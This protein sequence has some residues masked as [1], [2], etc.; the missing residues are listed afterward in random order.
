VTLVLSALTFWFVP[1]TPMQ[2][3]FLSDLEKISLLEHV[4][5]NQTG[6]SNRQH[7][8][9]AQLREA[10]SDPQLWAQWLIILLCG[11]GGGVI[12]TYS[13]T[14]IKGFGYTPKESA[15]LNMGGGAV[16]VTYCLLTSYGVRMFGQRWL[17]LILTAIPAII[18]GAIMAYLPKTHK[19]ALL[20]GIYLVNT[21]L[22]AVPI[23][24]AWV[25]ANVAGHTKRACATTLLN[26][27]FAT[28]N[29]IG[30]SRAEAVM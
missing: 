6:I 3:R 12:T 16:A 28:G 5:T 26:A 24:F 10:F 30:E 21:I 11:G 7:F 8:I 17:F 20:A 15:L 22:A 14:L 27:A 13:A 4:K 25:T 18:G 1:D 9:W 19:T 23:Q 29:I 2:A